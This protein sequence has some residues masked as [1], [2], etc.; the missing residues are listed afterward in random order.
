MSIASTV[1]IYYQP[2]VTCYQKRHQYLK[3]GLEKKE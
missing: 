2:I 3:L 1:E